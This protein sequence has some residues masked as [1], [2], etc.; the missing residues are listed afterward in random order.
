[1]Q[2]SAGMVESGLFVGLAIRR[3]D[4]KTTRSVRHRRDAAPL[5][6]DPT[7]RRVAVTKRVSERASERGVEGII[8][9]MTIGVSE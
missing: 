3:L 7:L 5:L 6:S 4:R 9:T 2:I 1:M 8:S